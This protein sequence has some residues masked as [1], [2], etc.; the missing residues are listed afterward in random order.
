[1]SSVKTGWIIGGA[2]LRVAGEPFQRLYRAWHAFV[3]YRN[4]DAAA[5]ISSSETGGPHYGT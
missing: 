5:E 2:I 1:M 4:A 3:E